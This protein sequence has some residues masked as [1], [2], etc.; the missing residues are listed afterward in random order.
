[1]SFLE[2]MFFALI[3]HVNWI[4]QVSQQ[5]KLPHILHYA[6]SIDIDVSTMVHNGWR[7]I[8]IDAPSQSHGG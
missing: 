5:F 7:S 3:L 1:M 8:D 6:I 2:E 4:L